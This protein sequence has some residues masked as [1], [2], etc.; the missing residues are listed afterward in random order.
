LDAPRDRNG[1]FEPRIVR[2]GPT[3][4][5]G[6]NERIIALY[7]R[8]LSTRDIRA[9]RREMYDVDVSADLISRLTDA[10]L[11]ELPEWQSTRWIACFR[12]WR[13]KPHHARLHREADAPGAR[14]MQLMRGCVPMMSYCGAVLIRFGRRWSHQASERPIAAHSR[15]PVVSDVVHKTV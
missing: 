6:F 3:R 4:S 10:V 8:G 5:D 2:K 11:E 12:W 13:Q 9:H 1:S 7:A 14:R 15:D